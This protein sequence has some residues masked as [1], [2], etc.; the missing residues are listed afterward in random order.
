VFPYDLQNSFATVM[1]PED[2]TTL[3]DTALL[4]RL[5]EQLDPY[6]KDDVVHI[7]VTTLIHQQIETLY[8]SGPIGLEEAIYD[9]ID[10]LAMSSMPDGKIKALL[11][12]TA[13]CAGREMRE[14]FFE[15]G[16]VSLLLTSE[17]NTPTNA[18]KLAE[19]CELW[20]ALYPPLAC[21][22]SNHSFDWSE[23]RHAEQ[24]ELMMLTFLRHWR[25]RFFLAVSHSCED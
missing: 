5:Y 2:I 8:P 9:R 17:V 14:M 7:L 18:K 24:L 21:N 20:L 11:V 3:S 23:F 4:V 15:D 10:D 6:C 12:S 19:R 13:E 25:K 22:P 16:L 1:N